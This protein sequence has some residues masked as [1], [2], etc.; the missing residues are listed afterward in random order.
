MLAAID[1][2]HQIRDHVAYPG[3]L[4]ATGRNDARVS[5][6]MPAKFAARLQAATAGPRPVLLRVNDAGGHGGGTREQ[7]QAEEA[8]YYAFLLWQAGVPDFQPP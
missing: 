2:F 7:S 8:D 6:W 4:V 1:A 5:P 3:V